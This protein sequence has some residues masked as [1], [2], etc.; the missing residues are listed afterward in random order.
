MRF[1]LCFVLGV[2]LVSGETIEEKGKRIVD[3]A[4]AAL[5][6]DRFLAMNDR[7]E[8]GRAYSFYREELSG[9]SVAKIYTRY[10]RR[11]DDAG[12]GWLGIEERQAFGRDEYSAVL[13]TGGKGYEVTFRGARLLPDDVMERFRLSTL[14]DIFYIL[15]QR[16]AEKGLIFESRGSDVYQNQP[17]EMV[18]ITDSENR[19]VKV[20][21]HGSTKLP[22]REVFFRHDPKTK[23]RIEENVDYGKYRDVGGGVFWPYY[24]LKTRDGERIYQ[25]FSE[26]V[27]IN[28]GLKD[29]LFTLPANM[30]ILKPVE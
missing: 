28:Q 11:P 29:S 21:F 16:L 3:E 1:L 6:G 2:S 8:A 9:L 13:F 26:T 27:T 20:Y 30:K 7:V 17:I 15:R 24:M 14:H 10:P 25:I 12:P 22:V 23:N 4:L 19:V 5:G 18:D